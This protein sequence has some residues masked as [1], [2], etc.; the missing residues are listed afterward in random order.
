MA[1]ERGNE[2]AASDPLSPRRRTSAPSA[3]DQKRPET[4]H[5][6]PSFRG[7]VGLIL[8]GLAARSRQ[9]PSGWR[10][11]ARISAPSVAPITHERPPEDGQGQPP[12]VPAPWRAIDEVARRRSFGRRNVHHQ[13]PGPPGRQ[14]RRRVQRP[15]REVNLAPQPGRAKIPR[16]PE[17]APNRPRRPGTSLKVNFVQEAGPPRRTAASSPRPPPPARP[18]ARRPA[19]PG[20]PSC[21]RACS[22]RQ[23]PRQEQGSKTGIGRC[24]A[25]H[26]G[27][28]TPNIVDQGKTRRPR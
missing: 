17:P 25:F 26:C 2:R 10:D 3:D 7:G 8:F 24:F 5:G 19:P 12:S 6:Q 20:P 23:V 27:R 22:A 21:P 15:P 13:R 11:T 9:C 4:G 16:I 18:P 28:W 14:T 1:S